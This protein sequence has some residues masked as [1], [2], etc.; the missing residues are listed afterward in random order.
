ML[1][2]VLNILKII[3]IILLCLLALVLLVI[4]L[5]LF[6]PIRY[7]AQGEYK[8]TYRLEAKVTWLARLISIRVEMSSGQALHMI[9]KLFG[10]TVYDN[11]KPAAKKKAPKKKAAKKEKEPQ[12]HAAAKEKEQ[13]P[14]PKPQETQ[15]PPLEET[16]V[17]EE[18]AGDNADKLTIL[19]KIYL[20]FE[21]IKHFLQN[22]KYTFSKIYG[23]IVNIKS[24]IS[25]YCNL[26]TQESTKAAFSAAYK[27]IRRIFR[28]LR[29]R[30]WQVNLH[31]GREN[32]ADM[33]DIMA[34]WGMLYP[35]HEGRIAISAEYDRDVFEGDFRMRGR[36]HVFLYLWTACII[37]FDKNIKHFKK[38][39][40]REEG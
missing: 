16:P 9:L 21:K 11:T 40:L 5:I 24:N 13:Q 23:T 6:W 7:K 31:I 32:P 25:Y 20:F 8:E 22:I 33:G 39:L 27:P 15:Q 18:A 34:V 28:N 26:M 19:Q 35:L 1:G 36:I 12:L 29:P 17:E 38:C 3:G 37:L 4:C 30:R 2:I 14:A 10:L